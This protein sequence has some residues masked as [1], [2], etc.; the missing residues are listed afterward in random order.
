LSKSSGAA[1]LQI[2]Q[3]LAVA[4]VNAGGQKASV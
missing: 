2:E 3:S 1:T 4:D